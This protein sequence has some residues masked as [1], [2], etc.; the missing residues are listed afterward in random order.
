MAYIQWLRGKIGRRKII[1]VYASV[2]LRDE[3]G[4]VLLLRKADAGA[5][6]LPGGALEPG[7]SILDCAHRGLREE[8]GLTAGELRLVGVYTD[9]RYDPVYPNGDQTQQYTVCFQCKLNGGSMQVDGLEANQQAFFEPGK[10]PFGELPDFYVA[11]LSDAL[12]GGR[13]SNTRINEDNEIA[14]LPPF[15]STDPVDP[16]QIVRPL[17]GQALYIAAGAIA[18]CVRDDGRLLLVK[19]IDDGEWTLPGGY[20]N[21]GENVAHTAVREALEETGLQAA[22]ERILGV[23]SPIPPW[24]YPNGDPVQV[25]LTVFRM[26]PREGEPRPDRTEVSQVGWFTPQELLEVETHP[27]WARL[28]RAVVEHLEEGVFLI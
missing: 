9:P 19:R 25:V 16:I 8:S 18:V 15:T 11:M 13:Q 6:G 2:V 26:R 7:E 14:F 17:I 12:R 21:L 23:Y 27:V 24:V 4:K 1:L 5:W 28:N 3:G 20:T 22:P 10:I